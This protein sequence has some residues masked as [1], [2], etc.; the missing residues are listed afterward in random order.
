M[1]NDRQACPT[2]NEKGEKGEKMKVKL[3][4]LAC[5]ML[6]GCASEAYYKALEAQANRP[7]PPPVQLV[8]HKWTDSSGHVQQLVVNQPQCPGIP[9]QQ[10]AAIPAPWDGTYKFF[11][12]ILGAVERN[13]PWLYLLTGG[14]AGPSTTY[15]IGGDGTINTTHGDGAGIA[16]QHDLTTIE[17]AEEE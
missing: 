16:Y 3:T 13:F 11:D 5:L 12:R 1:R 2:I 7:E 9:S 4:V 17:A 14:G 8:N 15:H 10:I 6:S